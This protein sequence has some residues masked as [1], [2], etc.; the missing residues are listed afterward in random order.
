MKDTVSSCQSRLTDDD[1]SVLRHIDIV[2]SLDSK[3]VIY[4]TDGFASPN[5]GPGGAGV[6]IFMQNRHSH[7]HGCWSWQ[8][9][10]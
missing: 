2:C 3:A 5:P 8:I 9:N 6:A 7:R 1:P 4:Y 10:K